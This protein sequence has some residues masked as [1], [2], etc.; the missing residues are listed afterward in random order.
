MNNE[1]YYRYHLIF[2]FVVMFIGGVFV[3]IGTT[4]PVYNEAGVVVAVG[5][6][7]FLIIGIVLIVLAFV[8]MI[9]FCEHNKGE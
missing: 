1:D 8:G 7:P 4:Y 2:Y 3:W 5:W 6:L 9:F